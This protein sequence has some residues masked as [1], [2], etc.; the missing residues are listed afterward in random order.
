MKKIEYSEHFTYGKLLRCSLPSIGNMLVLMSFQV[1]DGFFVS[2]L[3]G[4]M[5]YSSV[6]LIYPVFM[7]LQAVGYMFGAGSSA[8]ISRKL[9]AGQK[10]QANEIF[11]M[12]VMTLL[13]VGVLLAA[14]A[15]LLMPSL[16]RLVGATENTM[17]NCI[18]YG[19]TLMYFLPAFLLNCAFQTLWIAAG[20][21]GLGLCVSLV[22]GVGNAFL[23]WLLMSV[24]EMR[25]D[26]A[27]LATSI[28]AA[29]SATITIIYFLRD[30]KTPLRFS[31]V[32]FRTLKEI[33][34]MLY[35][36][37]SEMVEG[38]A[39][40]FTAM[41]TNRQLIRYVSEVGVAANGVFNNVLGLFTSVYF[42]IS[43]T[44]VAIA[45]YK[46]GQKDRDE[47]NSLLK[48]TVILNFALGA[49]ISAATV[50]LSGTFASIFLG[51][52]REACD[53]ATNVLRIGSIACLFYGFDIV[54]SSFFTGI[55]DGTASAVVAVMMALIMPIA[56]IYLIPYL[57]GAQAIWFCV[58][59]NTIGAAIV[60]A[61]FIRFRYPKR[62]AKL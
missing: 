56:T 5:P 28:A 4:V 13:A 16:A 46:V 12:S 6:T 48:T 11:T 17:E 19:R 55:G 23:D 39:G 50:L 7:V 40:N 8:L 32:H 18:L 26:G 49:V 52:D 35:N 54:T 29:V 15:S 58:P 44:T 20:K 61:A 60:C 24:F 34:G 62:L 22:Y 37:S 30:N 27:A 10:E 31:E 3:L 45:G 43:T 9:G 57:F 53:L 2:N 59:V 47:L 1:V 14:G 38:I 42:G 51:Y 33:T 36:G 21:P 41:L 25:V